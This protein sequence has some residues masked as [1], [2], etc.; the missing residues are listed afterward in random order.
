MA[1]TEAHRISMRALALA[2]RHGSLALVAA[3]CSQGNVQPIICL[4]TDDHNGDQSYVPLAVL[5]GAESAQFFRSL[6]WPSLAA[7]IAIPTTDVEGD[8]DE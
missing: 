5:G 4:L 1:L 2:A 8:H 7:P 6:F 3:R